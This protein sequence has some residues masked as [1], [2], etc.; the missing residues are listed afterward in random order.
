MTTRASNTFR[1]VS[2]HGDQVFGEPKKLK[3]SVELA[4]R[5]VLE[6]RQKG[7]LFWADDS[8]MLHKAEG[9]RDRVWLWFRG[10]KES[11]KVNDV[12]AS[13]LWH[14]PLDGTVRIKIGKERFLDVHDPSSQEEMRRLKINF[15]TWG[16]NE[17]LWRLLTRRQGEGLRVNA[18]GFLGRAQLSSLSK[19]EKQAVQDLVNRTLSK[20]IRDFEA[21]KMNRIHKIVLE[22]IFTKSPLTQMS[23]KMYDRSVI[24][25]GS[26]LQKRLKPEYAAQK[27]KLEDALKNFNDNFGREAQESARVAMESTRVAIADELIRLSDCERELAQVLGLELKPVA[28]GGSGGAVYARDRLGHKIQV[29]KR[30]DA[31]PF[32]PNNKS[33]TAWFKSFF[34]SQR[35]CLDGNSEPLAE[36]DCYRLDSCFI[37]L[38]LV[39]P[40]KMG[41]VQSASFDNE[42]I[43]CSIQMWIDGCKTL[44][45]YLDFNAHFLPRSFL[46]W[47]FDDEKYESKLPQGLMERVGILDFLSENI[48]TH[49]ENVLVKVLDDKKE[50]DV[51]DRLLKGEE[52]AKEEIA[53]F[54]F[55]L[56]S[57]KETHKKYAKILPHSLMK[58]LI[59]HEDFDKHLDAILEILLDE[60]R[61]DDFLDRLFDKDKTVHPEEITNFVNQ[62]F[63]RNWHQKLLERLF[64]SETTKSGKRV[65]LVKHDGGSSNPHSHPTSWDLLSLRFK[66]FIEVLPSFKKP[67]SKE[68]KEAIFH[69]EKEAFQEFIYAKIEHGLES[70]LSARVAKIFWDLGNSTLVKEWVRSLEKMKES[71][72]TTLEEKLMEA[73]HKEALERGKSLS[74]K[75]IEMHKKYFRRNLKRLQGNIRTRWE[76]WIVL[77]IYAGNDGLSM[78]DFLQVRTRSD[79]TRVLPPPELVE[80]KLNNDPDEGESK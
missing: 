34:I 52:I 74:S 67:L 35:P 57:N 79:F 6:T 7:D 19:K 22:H 69:P 32:G 13:T 70:I 54:V 63:S 38:H 4:N 24:Q 58:L 66:H 25:E 64:P 62:L 55:H 65:L 40:T 18:R 26:K 59:V 51:L 78:R 45:E 2:S 11:L 37:H 3:D 61:V 42:K 73:V 46:R 8:Q 77:K 72:M 71:D 31:G 5:Q 21:V 23:R 9:W 17:N 44:S 10:N 28:E 68:A 29:I 39:P 30:T 14:A 12:V 36:Y 53:E 50:D 41:D 20:L 27:A 75:D 43:H 56:F 49:L 33:W 76:S 48:D 60:R 47:Y 1:F 80:Q 16:K 15:E